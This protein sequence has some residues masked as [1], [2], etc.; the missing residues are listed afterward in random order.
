VLVLPVGIDRPYFCRPV[1]TYWIMG[2]CAAV[3]VIRIA[4]W[5]EADLLISLGYIP[6]Y[7]SVLS[8]FTSMFLHGGPLHLL[9]NMLFLYV[10]GIKLEDV[11]G[12]WRYLLLYLGGGVAANALHTAVAGG[13][14]IPCVGASGAIAG[15][16]GA[17]AVLY[18]HS[19]VKML[20]WFLWSHRTFRVV[21][22]LYLGLWFAK[23]LLSLMA[24]DPG[25][26]GVAFGAHVGGFAAGSFWAWAFFGWNAGDEMDGY[27]PQAA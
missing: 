10:T 27:A 26:S 3:E 23:E 4:L 19:K 8:I 20:Y 6:G 2:I 16:M 5:P 18:P 22:W 13:V 14:P 11:L 17:Y 21:A 24:D 9:G 25:S 12:P 7:A 15:V 1:V